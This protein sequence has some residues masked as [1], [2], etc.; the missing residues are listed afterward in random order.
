MTDTPEP[1]V[2]LPASLQFLRVLVTTLTAVMIVGMILI[3]A[4]IW[5]RYSDDAP[6]LPEAIALPDGAKPA[7]FT[8]GNGWYAV[9]TTDDTILIY[10]SLTGALTQTIALETTAASPAPQSK[11]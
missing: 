8:Q 7:A 6:P 3:V 10:N 5:T 4:L 9:V 11:P 1:E 2:E